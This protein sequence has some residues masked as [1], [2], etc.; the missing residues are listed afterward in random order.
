V[1]FSSFA[2][3][4]DELRSKI[5]TT[6]DNKVVENPKRAEMA[7]LLAELI[8]KRGKIKGVRSYNPYYRSSENTQSVLAVIA[9]DGWT[10]KVWVSN[11]NEN[12]GEG[13]PDTISFFGNPKHNKAT[14]PRL[15]FV[16]A[17]LDG[18]CEYGVILSSNHKHVKYYLLSAKRGME[19]KREMQQKYENIVSRLLMLYMQD[20]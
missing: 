7:R 16:D 18:N 1:I 15:S 11:S 10:W 13:Q 5:T 17:G 2:S 19:Y 4:A 12:E 20:N 14:M 8:I 9:I 6:P 3:H